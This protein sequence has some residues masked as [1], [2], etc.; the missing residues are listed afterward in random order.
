MKIYTISCRIFSNT[1]N[2][3]QILIFLCTFLCYTILTSKQRVILLQ[4]T[5]FRH[6]TYFKFF[7]IILVKRCMY[8]AYLKEVLSPHILLD[9]GSMTKHQAS[10]AY[11]IWWKLWSNED[12]GVPTRSYA[13]SGSPP[14][15][16]KISLCYTLIRVHANKSTH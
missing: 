9:N 6:P 5:E 14:K 1:K 16:K 8:V 10:L 4:T 12:P 2:L 11:S 13:Q 7:S 3:Q 15:V